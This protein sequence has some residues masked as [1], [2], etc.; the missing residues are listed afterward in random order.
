MAY[1]LLNQDSSGFDL[2][3]YKYKSGKEK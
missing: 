1:E 3:Y 2:Y